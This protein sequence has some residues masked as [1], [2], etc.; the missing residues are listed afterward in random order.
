MTTDKTKFTGNGV[1]GIVC[2]AGIVG[3]RPKHRVLEDTL[4]AAVSAA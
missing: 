3:R 1:I 2:V 4:L